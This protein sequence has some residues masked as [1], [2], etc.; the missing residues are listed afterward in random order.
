MNGNG[1]EV[2]HP[3][4]LRFGAMLCD[5][6]AAIGFD[7]EEEMLDTMEQAFHAGLN[8]NCEMICDWQDKSSTRRLRI[9][10]KGS[11][12]LFEAL[13]LTCETCDK[14]ETCSDRRDPHEA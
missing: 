13:C 10:T 3:W 9:W 7:T 11:A 5:E 12:L 14:R 6:T 4:S 2:C 1:N 8:E